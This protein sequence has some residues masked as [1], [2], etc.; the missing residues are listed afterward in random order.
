MQLELIHST[1]ALR[2]PYPL[3]RTSSISGLFTYLNGYTEVS[4]ITL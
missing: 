3:I 1:D 2:T 4:I